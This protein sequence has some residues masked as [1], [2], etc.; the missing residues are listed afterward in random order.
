MTRP[1]TNS[2][3]ISANLEKVGAHL[4]AG[5]QNQIFETNEASFKRMVRSFEKKSMEEIKQAWRK[6]ISYERI[7]YA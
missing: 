2:E 7:T 5:K 1:I 3:A 6:I 4:K